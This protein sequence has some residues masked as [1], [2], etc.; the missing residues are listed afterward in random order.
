LV[1]KLPRLVANDGL[2]AEAEQQ[3]VLQTLEGVQEQHGDGG[4]GQHAA[5]VHAPGLRRLRLRADETVD[6]QLDA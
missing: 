2:E 1:V 6:H 3:M 4:E 5:R